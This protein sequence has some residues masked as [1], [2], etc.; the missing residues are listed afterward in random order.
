MKTDARVTITLDYPV[1]LASGE[2]TKVTMRRPTM[3][4]QIDFPMSEDVGTEMKLY[5]RLTG[6]DFEDVCQLDMEDY[7]KLQQ[8]FMLF[9]TPDAKRNKAGHADP[10]KNN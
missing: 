5:A 7:E 10:G 2:V 6:L 4:E 3:Q 9:R 8:Q 1:K